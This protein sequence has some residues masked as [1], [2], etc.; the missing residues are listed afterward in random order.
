MFNRNNMNT[1]SDN[2]QHEINSNNEP[3]LLVLLNY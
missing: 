3:D 1:I 2:T